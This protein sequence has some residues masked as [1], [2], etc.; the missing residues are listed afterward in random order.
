[1]RLRLR[2]RPT[3]LLQLQKR[4]TAKADKSIDHSRVLAM[5][6]EIYRLLSGS[7]I[8]VRVENSSSYEHTGIGHAMF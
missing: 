5:V 3:P 1:M 6:A 4:E 7:L 8:P 2:E